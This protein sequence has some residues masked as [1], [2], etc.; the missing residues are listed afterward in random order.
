[1][2]EAGYPCGEDLGGLP[3]LVHAQQVVQCYIVGRSLEVDLRGWV[4]FQ[5]FHKT[6]GFEDG[7]DFGLM[8][9]LDQSKPPQP[10][11]TWTALRTLIRTVAFCDY[12]F[13]H[14][15]AGEF[16]GT[17]PFVL[18]FGRAQKPGEKLW[19]I[20]SPQ[21]MAKEAPVSREVTIRLAPAVKARLVSMLGEERTVTADAEGRLTVMS[22]GAP[23][24][25]LAEEK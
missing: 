8:T 24:Y 5:Y 13:E 17:G 7:A 21:G 23:V 22:T 12:A 10:R 16:N 2:N 11:P 20:F 19:V 25:L 18:R 1:M 3:E 6:H 4:Y 15:D 14:R 9:A